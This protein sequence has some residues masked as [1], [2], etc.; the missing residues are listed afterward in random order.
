MKIENLVSGMMT[1]SVKGRL[2]HWLTPNAQHHK[3]FE[4]FL[5]ENILLTDSFVESALGNSL[6][7]ALEKG[8]SV[9]KGSVDSYSIDSARKDLAA[10]RDE[11]RKAQEELDLKD[12]GAKNELTTI[13][14][15]VI[16]LCSKTTY[17]L[18]LK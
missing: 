8:V 16:E 5:N 17:M 10:Y 14:D 7:V 13:L 18:R 11:A 4:D 3:V 6:D 12:E 1:M 15:D 9:N 2:W